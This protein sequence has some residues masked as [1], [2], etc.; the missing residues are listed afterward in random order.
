MISIIACIFVIYF[1]YYAWIA[2]N[3]DKGGNLKF[4]GKKKKTNDSI[5]AEF[6]F[7]INKYKIDISKVNKRY[8]LRFLALIIAL[9]LSITVALMGLFKVL[10]LKIVVGFILMLVTVFVS[11]ELAGNYFKKKGLIIDDKTNNKRQR[12]RK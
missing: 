3:Y 11:Y 8:F 7:F 6:E 2:Y 4:H 5:P 12:K 10:W 9:D 1:I